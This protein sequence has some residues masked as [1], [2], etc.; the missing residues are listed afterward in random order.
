MKQSFG[1]HL[2]VDKNYLNKI[3]NA[4][5]LTI[6]DIVVEIGAGSGLLTCEL[7]KIA[8]KVIAVEL[9]KSILVKLKENLKLKNVN[10]VEVIESNF[11]KLDLVKLVNKPFKI[12]G[13]IP[14]NITS[15]ILLKIFGEID[16]IAP[17]FDF[18]EDVFLTI[19]KEVALRLTAISGTKAYSPISIL[20]QYFSK[21]E[22]LFYIPK[23]VFSPPPKVNSAFV[24]FQLRRK[25]T[26][27]KN[28]KF[29]KTLIRTAFQ[30]RRKKLVNSLNSLFEDKKQIIE[31]FNKLH[32]DHNLRAENLNLEQYLAISNNI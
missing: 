15:K 5:N 17:H 14:Y 32:L 18:L 28:P 27:I 23:S 20:V 24:R 8:K 4:C 22:I 25:L 1:Q 7:A 16:N 2:L 3:I 19:Q 26:E 9:E 12:I 31:T 11:L 30:Q 13:N 29:L 21:P 6:S 10:N